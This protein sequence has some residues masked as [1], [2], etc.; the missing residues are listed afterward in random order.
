MERQHLDLIIQNAAHLR[1]LG[2]YSASRFDLDLVG[3]LPW[4]EE[5]FGC[6]TDYNSPVISALTETYIKEYGYQ[7]MRRAN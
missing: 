7:M 2:L 6:W 5:F 3:T 1:Q 4:T